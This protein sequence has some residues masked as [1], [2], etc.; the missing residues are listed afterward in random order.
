MRAAQTWE[1]AILIVA[2]GAL[3]LLL[4]RWARAK[5]LG[6]LFRSLLANRPRPQYRAFVYRLRELYFKDPFRYLS[7]I[8]SDQGEW[9]V[10]QLWRET[11]WQTARLKSDQHG[12]LPDDGFALHRMH[13]KDGRAMAI[14]TLPP[15]QRSGETYMVG[16][17]LPRDDSFK[18][19]LNRA[20]RS[21]RLFVLNMWQLSRETD[22]CE[23]TSTGRELTYNI[24]APRNPE[25]FAEAI[26]E[27]L[28][29]R[30]RSYGR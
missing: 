6:A 25:G 3:A 16:L 8:W 14:V 20:R 4:L 19:D 9:F 12:T 7:M 10:R 22:F 5:F 29:A 30:P 1:W 27:K 18:E 15:P 24:G 2:T 17:V 11:G 23:W 28:R 13:T 26:E 21:A